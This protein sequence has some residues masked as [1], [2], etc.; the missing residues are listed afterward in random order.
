MAKKRVSFIATKYRDR[1][2]R[3]HFYTKE[4]KRVAFDAVKRV[5]TKKS[6]S[7]YVEATMIAR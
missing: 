5:P 4:G 1:P 3:V 2:A 7:F 6:I